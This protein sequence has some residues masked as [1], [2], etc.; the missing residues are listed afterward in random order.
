MALLKRRGLCVQA[1]K[2]QA[3][4]VAAGIEGVIVDDW[5]VCQFKPGRSANGSSDRQPTNSPSTMLPEKYS[6]G[7]KIAPGTRPEPILSAI[8]G[9]NHAQMTGWVGS[10]TGMVHRNFC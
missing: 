8:T 9:G 1:E 5:S 3:N 6:N 10:Q 2:I 7:T 4:E